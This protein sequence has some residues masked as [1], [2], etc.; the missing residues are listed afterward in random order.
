MR[1][2]NGQGRCSLCIWFG[3]LRVRPLLQT[4][5]PLL[6]CQR[7][8][9]IAMYIATLGTLSTTFEITRRSP[10][11]STSREN[12]YF[13]VHVSRRFAAVNVVLNLPTI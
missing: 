11:A 13:N 10:V 5:L 3:G 4:E 9:Q 6:C 1:N 7:P 12:C 2:G 8:K